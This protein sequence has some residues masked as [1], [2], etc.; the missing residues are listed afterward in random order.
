MSHHLQLNI[1]WDFIYATNRFLIID[2]HYN[3]L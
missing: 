2:V 3:L 1:E